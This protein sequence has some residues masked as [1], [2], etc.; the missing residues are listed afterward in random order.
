VGGLPQRPEPPLNYRLVFSVKGLIREYLSARMIKRGIVENVVP[1]DKIDHHRFKP[2]GLLEAFYTDGLGSALYTMRD[3][4]ILDEK[5][6]RWP[7]HGEKIRFLRDCGFFSEEPVRAGGASVVPVDFTSQLL[8]KVLSRGDPKDVTVMRVDVL[9]TRSGRKALVRYE[10]I[11]YYDDEN[12]ITSMGRTTGFTAAIIA[13]MVGRGELVGT[14]VRGPESIL[15]GKMVAKLIQQLASK[16]VKIV[17]R[18][19]SGKER[20]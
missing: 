6:L 13:R 3:F 18:T 12:R 5:T 19:R 2:I 8:Y 16:G 7:G 4:D 11:D 15:D 14:G 20:N 10:M 17:R 9:G 1:F